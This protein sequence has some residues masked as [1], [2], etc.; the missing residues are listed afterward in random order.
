MSDGDQ[1]AKSQK[2]K[3]TKKEV[4]LSLETIAGGAASECRLI[5]A[6]VMVTHSRLHGDCVGEKRPRGAHRSK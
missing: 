2:D 6:S 4:I 1:Q 3:E 5:L